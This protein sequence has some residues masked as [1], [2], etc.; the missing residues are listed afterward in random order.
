MFV[1]ELPDETTAEVTVSNT[2]QAVTEIL[3]ETLGP[4]PALIT[5]SNRELIR[6]FLAGY[7]LSPTDFSA[8]KNS[9]RKF[10]FERILNL[11]SEPSPYL[12]FGNAV[13]AAMKQAVLT[14]RSG[15]VPTW[16]DVV[17]IF[18]DVIRNGRLDEHETGYLLS[19]GEK[20]LRPFFESEVSGITGSSM[21]EYSFREHKLKVNDVPLTGK[22]DRFDY[23]DQSKT[24]GT[25]IDYKTGNPTSL[26]GKISIRKRS[27]DY[28]DQLKFYQLLL[29]NSPLKLKV[30]EAVI[31]YVDPGSDGRFVSFRFSFSADEIEA[32]AQEV[33]D[34]YQ[35]ILR[36]EFDDPGNMK[37]AWYSDFPVPI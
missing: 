31:K 26:T 36:L 27:G 24:S 34:V 25:V 20:R 19:T 37:D 18:T 32:F 2:E 30:N 29:E 9:P 14:A 17:D 35:R 21:V 3:A 16:Q 6:E 23:A 15:E 11:P 8:Y 12:V 1:E 13:H 7:R 5:D 4:A 10:F 33:Q 28:V 22:I